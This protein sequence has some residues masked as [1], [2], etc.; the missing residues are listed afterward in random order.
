MDEKEEEKARAKYKIEKCV[1]C[2]LSVCELAHEYIMFKKNN[3]G[4]KQICYD[5][6]DSRACIIKKINI[7]KC[8][9]KYVSDGIGDHF[10]INLRENL[11]IEKN[12]ID[13]WEAAQPVFISAPT[14]AGKNTFIEGE[15]LQYMRKFNY[16][17]GIEQRV[18][19]ISNRIALK[20]QILDRINSGDDRVLDEEKIYTNYKNFPFADVISYQGF[21]N[22]A[23]NFKRIQEDKSARNRR[24]L[25]VICDEAHFFTSDAM[26]NHDTERI[27]AA[28][29]SIFQESI[30]IYMTATPYDCLEHIIH[31]ERQ[32]EN[33]KPGF[34]VFYHFPRNYDYLDIKYYS[35]ED[36]LLDLIAKSKEKWLIFIDDKEKCRTYKDKLYN[37]MEKNSITTPESEA[38]EKKSAAKKDIVF[39]VDAD[40]KRNEK[41][42]KMVHDEKFPDETKVLITTSVL[43][44]GI[45]FKDPKIK[46]IVVADTSK[47]KILQEVGRIRVGSPNDKVTLYIKG[48]MKKH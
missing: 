32:N 26:F 38:G 42:R 43:D 7:V 19:I 16:E 44:N 33:R 9:A 29:P 30:R 1:G 17:N 41:Y 14:G 12:T 18:L 5:S 34:G 45:N 40:S 47:T 10:K 27:L 15:I 25:F 22:K 37:Y 36:E 28:I 21:L 39:A 24:Y 31:Y 20:M 23:E 46:H 2:P 48:M 13:K 11:K 3:P 8:D 35:H 6:R 4:K